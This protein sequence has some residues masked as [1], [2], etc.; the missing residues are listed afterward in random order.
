MILAMLNT[1]CLCGTTFQDQVS[2]ILDFTLAFCRYFYD[3][4]IKFNEK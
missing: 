2:D 3:N 1:A 4:F